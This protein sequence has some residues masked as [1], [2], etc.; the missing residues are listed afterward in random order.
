MAAF[1][2]VALVRTIEKA[3]TQW[4]PPNQSL[5]F[6][7]ICSQS[8][9][10]VLTH[11]GFAIQTA[12]MIIISQFG[13]D[14]ASRCRCCVF[15]AMSVFHFIYP[16]R[17]YSVSPFW[18]NFRTP[19]F[20]ISPYPSIPIFFYRRDFCT[21]NTLLL[22][23]YPFSCISFRGS[24]YDCTRRI[25]TTLLAILRVRRSRASLAQSWPMPLAPLVVRPNRTPERSE[26]FSVFPIKPPICIF[27][28]FLLYFYIISLARVIEKTK[29]RSDCSE[30]RSHYSTKGSYFYFLFLFVKTYRTKRENFLI[31]VQN[32]NKNYRRRQRPR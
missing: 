5:A 25:P 19:Q 32:P 16:S 4:H 8:P 27:Y 13:Q 30:K 22:G 1:A 18:H 28:F 10:S 24:R 11:T 3:P 7:A 29:N 21:P 6:G 17:L 9:L 31:F 20:D 26:R 2:C 23:N 14:I 12:R 15:I